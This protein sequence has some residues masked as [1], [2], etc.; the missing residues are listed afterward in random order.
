MGLV[1]QLASAVIDGRA[2]TTGELI[3]NC[4][5]LVIGGA[6]ATPFAMTGAL[7][8]LIQAPDQWERLRSGS[9]DLDSAVEELLRWTSP[10]MYF[11]RTA[12]RAFE[13]HGVPIA[14]GDVVTG[15]Y[16]S[17]NFDPD[18]FPDPLTLDLGR[19]PNRHLAFAYGHHFC[20]GASLA[21]L[22]LRCLLKA[23]RELGVSAELI[24]APGPVYSSFVSGF[25]SL[26]VRLSA[27]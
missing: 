23:I 19:Q 27:R 13:L 21:R 17:A 6:E 22:E 11:G 14:E 24:G 1:A 5:N 7:H 16:R 2:L 3:S 10:A 18:E 15:W 8:A 9:V 20:V 4:Y 26:P 25:S 12:T